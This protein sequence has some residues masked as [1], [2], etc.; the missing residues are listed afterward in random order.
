MHSN[1]HNKQAIA[2]AFSRAADRYEHFA[3][4]Q[5]TVGDQLKAEC[6]WHNT[7]ILLDAGAGS[8]WYSRQFRQSGL[9]VIALDLAAGMLQQAKQHDSADGYLQA[10][11]EH[12]PLH[13]NSID[14]L[15]S[16]LALQ[17]CSDFKQTLHHLHGCLKPTGKLAFSTL[18]A[19]SLS[20]LQQVWQSLGLAAPI[21][22]WSPAEQLILQAQGLN[23]KLWQAPVVCYFP[24]AMAALWSLKGIGASH[25]HS[26]RSSGLAGKQFFTEVAAR[27]PREEQGFRLTYQIVFGVSL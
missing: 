10:D 21:N 18:A 7:G 20:E 15:W 19:G 5:R 25:L 24:S 26:G 3:A 23:L 6:H 17:W 13:R 22:Q 9:Q 8:G 16:N 14:Y 4:F 11:L 2:K 1:Q 12:L 27:W